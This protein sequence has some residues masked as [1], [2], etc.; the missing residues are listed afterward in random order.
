MKHQP[1][2]VQKNGNNQAVPFWQ[3]MAPLTVPI[4]QIPVSYDLADPMGLHGAIFMTIP[5]RIWDAKQ[6]V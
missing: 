4:Y 6:R 2:L 5:P 3:I 1:H